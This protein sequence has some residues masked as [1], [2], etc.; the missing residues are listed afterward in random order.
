MTRGPPI[1]YHGP[2]DGPNIFVIDRTNGLGRGARNVFACTEFEWKAAIHFAA[3]AGMESVVDALLKKAEECGVEGYV[4]VRDGYGYT[5]LHLACAGGHEQLIRRLYEAGADP[6]AAESNRRLRPFQMLKRGVAY[7]ESTLAMLA[8]TSTRKALD[9]RTRK[10]AEAIRARNEDAV[11]ALYTDSLLMKRAVQ[12]ADQNEGPLSSF[13]QFAAAFHERRAAAV[14]F[15]MS[16]RLDAPRREAAALEELKA[17][18]VCIRTHNLSPEH[19]AYNIDLLCDA[20]AFVSSWVNTLGFS[21]WKASEKFIPWHNLQTLMCVLGGESDLG[22]YVR[23]NAIQLVEDLHTLEKKLVLLSA[24]D[25]AIERTEPL[26]FICSVTNLFS[27]RRSLG[28]I[29]ACEEVLTK[30][31]QRSRPDKARL[32]I[33]V[34]KRVGEQSKFSHQCRNLS[35]EAKSLL[36]NVPWYLLARLRDDLAHGYDRPGSRPG[37]IAL[38]SASESD[39]SRL[40]E[41]LT[42]LVSS[43]KEEQ[44]TLC[45]P[46]EHVLEA[47]YKTEPRC[48]EPRLAELWAELL[49]ALQTD[50]S[51]LTKSNQ[52]QKRAELLKKIQC[53]IENSN[54]SQQEYEE[55]QDEILNKFFNDATKRQWRKT[56][57]LPSEEF[58]PIWDCWTK[59]QPW[60]QGTPS[61]A[62][63]KPG[64]KPSAGDGKAAAAASATPTAAEAKP[65]A[66][67]DARDEEK[68]TSVDDADEPSSASSTTSSSSSDATR[69][70]DINWRDTAVEILEELAKVLLEDDNL[71]RDLKSG[72]ATVHDDEVKLRIFPQLQRFNSDGTLRL[73]AEQLFIDLF[74]V[75]NRVPELRMIESHAQLRNQLEHRNNV[76]DFVDHPFDQNTF[77]MLVKC[78]FVD[79]QSVLS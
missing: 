78:V 50:V 75:T 37:Y 5:P 77:L 54:L 79:M 61:S 15:H 65:E 64:T 42:K 71:V 19:C 44:K 73:I 46:A 70:G 63:T 76:Y 38:F 34:L 17:L 30:S 9:D 6:M 49:P 18:L 66:A 2:E 12:F 59:F 14:M 39:L 52:R 28:M 8:E 22:R 11:K 1:V 53:R 58:A 35:H 62:E 36:P 43:C 29:A 25:A 33:A 57:A 32:L 3:E 20:A 26:S 47:L 68:K 45:R 4:N 24:G 21:Y 31:F 60:G 51:S 56:F 10:L 72:T 16:E 55:L 23:D 41:A 13:V 48:Y 67:G 69:G 74:V 40:A 7:D 27:D